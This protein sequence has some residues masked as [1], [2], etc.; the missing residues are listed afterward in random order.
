MHSIA[1]KVIQ[2]VLDSEYRDDADG[3]ATHCLVSLQGNLAGLNLTSFSLGDAAPT[4]KRMEEVND[5]LSEIVFYTIVLAY[6]NDND[7]AVYD[8]E[9]LMMFADG[10]HED[11]HND[12]I[13]C[14]SKALKAVTEI[15]EIMFETD[16]MMDIAEG[17]DPDDDDDPDPEDLLE[18]TPTE[19]AIATIFACVI[20]L[21]QQ[22]E[23]DLDVIV[24]NA[25]IMEKF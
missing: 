18:G 24:Y 16:T 2:T 10:I 3:L 11:Y 21:A 15:M 5:R 6:L 1:P 19:Q 25:G 14:G 4:G 22:F 17:F 9:A 12:R 23:L 7:L 20:L 8:R 13:L